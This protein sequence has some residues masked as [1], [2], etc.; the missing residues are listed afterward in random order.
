[1]SPGSCATGMLQGRFA[2]MNQA[3]MRHHLGSA[4]AEASNHNYTSAKVHLNRQSTA[5]LQNIA[6]MRHGFARAPLCRTARQPHPYR[7][8]GRTFRS[9]VEQ[10][11]PLG[12]WTFS[13]QVTIF[14]CHRGS[15]TTPARGA[16][17]TP[18]PAWPCF[19]TTPAAT[20]KHAR[21]MHATL[22]NDTRASADS[23]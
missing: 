11:Y 17:A 13:L 20:A 18:P 23:H 5:S 9:W 1:M 12:S 10:V 7:A 14:I 21:S 8:H 16:G 22:Q 2:H 19:I 15:A 6:T 3:T 4:P